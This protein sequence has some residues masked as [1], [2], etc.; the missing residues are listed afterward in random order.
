MTV[1]LT[2]LPTHAARTTGWSRS[3]YPGHHDALQLVLALGCAV[4]GTPWGLAMAVV[5]LAVLGA[6]RSARRVVD[7]SVAVRRG[8]LA[9]PHQA[10]PLHAAGRTREAATHP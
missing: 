7:R 5:V 3:H 6:R 2:H 9:S 4:A 10:R 8:V 1:H